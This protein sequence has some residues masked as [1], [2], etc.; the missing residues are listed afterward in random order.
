MTGI[1]KEDLTGKISYEPDNH[2]K[3]T[4][5]RFD[6]VAKIAQEIPP[7]KVACAQE[8]DL[9][10]T[11]SWGS[12][13]GATLTAAEEVFKMGKKIGHVHLRWLNPLPPDLLGIMKKFKKVVVPE[14][15]HGQLAYHL[16]GTFGVPIESYARVRGK[17][18]TVGELVTH[19]NSLLG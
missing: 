1:E 17:A 5:Y 3:M 2:E 13:Y 11:I 12:T 19:F 14:I 8:G 18:F 15:N 7:S 6:K 10:D 9:R 4:K 16:Q